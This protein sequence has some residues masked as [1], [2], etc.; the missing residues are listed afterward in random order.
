MT[1]RE[2]MGIPSFLVRRREA[3]VAFAADLRARLRGTM[4]S[5]RLIVSFSAA[6]WML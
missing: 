4:G 6:D 2:R 1:V 3:D 5:S